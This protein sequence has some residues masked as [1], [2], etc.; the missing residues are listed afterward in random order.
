MIVLKRSNIIIIL[1]LILTLFTTV[2]CLGALAFTP[3]NSIATA[4]IKVVIDAGHGGVDGG[5]VGVKTGI[6]ESELN[7]AVAKKLKKFFLSAGI[8]VVMTRDSD[9]GLY[10]TATKNLK[11]KDMQK[12]RDIINKAQPTIVIS[13]H[14]NKYSLSTRRGA[15][16]FFDEK[17]ENGKLLAS[18]VQNSLNGMDEAVRD[19]SALKGD[20]YILNSHTYPACIVECGFLSSPE[21]EELLITAEYQ[22]KIAYAIFK[23]SID[24]LTEAS[25]Y[26]K[27][28]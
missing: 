24:Y 16:V 4:Q 8:E 1:V 15:Q 22:E 3:E 19:C 25:F 14:M 5:V 7:L 23:G 11:R 20:Y 13:V 21:D 28:F 10:G 12:R 2:F 9:A 26:G 6:K 18:F 17:N 27:F